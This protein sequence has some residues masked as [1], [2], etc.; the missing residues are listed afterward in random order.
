MKINRQLFSFALLISIPFFPVLLVGLLF[1]KITGIYIPEKVEAIPSVLYP[2]IVNIKALNGITKPLFRA[3]E[4]NRS[5]RVLMVILHALSIIFIL[6]NLLFLP[7][8]FSQSTNY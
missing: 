6:I 2:I 3:K 5:L 7:M 4:K 8:A 1:T